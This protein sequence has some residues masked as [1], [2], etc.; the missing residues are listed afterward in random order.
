[1]F[2]KGSRVSGCIFWFGVLGYWEYFEPFGAFRKYLCDL[3]YLTTVGSRQKGFL[4]VREYYDKFY[5]DEDYSRVKYWRGID[6][7]IYKEIDYNTYDEVCWSYPW[8]RKELNY[9]VCLFNHEFMPAMKI[10]NWTKK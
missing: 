2:F 7:Y 9:P 4:R 6:V 1:M 5:E 3:G 8:N 10:E